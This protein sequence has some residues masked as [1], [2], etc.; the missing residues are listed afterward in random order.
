ME[1][2]RRSHGGQQEVPTRLVGTDMELI[3]M[4]TLGFSQEQCSSPVAQL[5][6]G[7]PEN[8][9]L[10]LAICRKLQAHYK[11]ELARLDL[12]RLRGDLVVVG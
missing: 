2:I 5:V 6:V 4:P 10:N 12:L 11:S 8:Q 7:S 9:I 1:G 3:T